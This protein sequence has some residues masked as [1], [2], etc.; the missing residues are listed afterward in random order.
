MGCGLVQSRLKIVRAMSV[1][2]R[3]VRAV[4]GVSAWRRGARGEGGGGRGAG[5]GKGSGA[6]VARALHR[7]IQCRLYGVRTP[8]M[9]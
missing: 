8:A 5:V 2:Q 3:T 9:P 6:Q 1:G 7:C 4:R